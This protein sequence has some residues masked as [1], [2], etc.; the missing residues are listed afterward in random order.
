M[1]AVL[2]QLAANSLAKTPNTQV[3][4]MTGQ[5]AMSVPLFWDEHDLPIGVQFAARFGDEVTLYRLAAQLE[6]VRPWRDRRPAIWLAHHNDRA[7]RVGGA[8]FA[9]RTQQQP[10][11][12]ATPRLPTT[13]MSASSASAASI[14]AAAGF[15]MTSVICTCSRS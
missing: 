7:V 3:Y 10:L 1:R 2:G 11:E 4:N 13:I 14:K 6:R 8:L 9:D 12:A 5:P 15:P